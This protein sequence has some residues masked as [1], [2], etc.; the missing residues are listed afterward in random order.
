MTHAEAYLVLL[1]QILVIIIPNYIAYK[2]IN[3]KE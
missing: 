2:Q 1:I 3:K